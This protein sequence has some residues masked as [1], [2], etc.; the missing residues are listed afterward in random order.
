MTDG[1]GLIGLVGHLTVSVPAH[2]PGEVVIAIRGGTESFAA[3]ADEP[4]AKYTRVVVV[5]ERSPRSVT[6]T[7]M[8]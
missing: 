3:W 2:G 1:N 4:I 8:P 5:E 6:V 7:P